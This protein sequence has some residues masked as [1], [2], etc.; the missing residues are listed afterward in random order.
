MGSTTSKEDTQPKAEQPTPAVEQD[1]DE[2]DE[3]DKRI[4]STG[5][6]DEN[7]KLTDCYYEK[8]DWRACRDEMERFKQCW[9]LQ[10]NDKRTDTKDA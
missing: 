10:G 2:P 5:C 9:K 8:K 4:F 3:W 1:D 7:T 6:A